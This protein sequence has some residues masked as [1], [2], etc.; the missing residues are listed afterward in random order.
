MGIDGFVDDS[1][2]ARTQFADELKLPVYGA[3]SE[4]GHDRGGV[5]GHGQKENDERVKW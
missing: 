3:A 5:G 4:V 1:V 2:G